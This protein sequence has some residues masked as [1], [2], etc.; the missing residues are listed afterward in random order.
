MLLMH[1]VVSIK[2]STPH[3]EENPLRINYILLKAGPFHVRGWTPYEH[4]DVQVA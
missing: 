2:I 1:N 4:P 3:M